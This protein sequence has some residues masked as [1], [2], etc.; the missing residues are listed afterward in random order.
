MSIKFS[1]VAVS[2]GLGAVLA[3]SP[4]WSQ[5]QSAHLTSKSKVQT[6]ASNIKKL[7]YG[8]NVGNSS[9]AHVKYLAH[10]KKGD[11]VGAVNNSNMSGLKHRSMRRAAIRLGTQAGLRWR[12]KHIVKQLK[13][14]ASQLDRR[15]NFGPLLIDGHVVPPVIKRVKNASRKYNRKTMRTVRVAYRIEHRARIVTQPPTWRSFLIQSYSKPKLPA[16]VLLPHSSKGKKI[17]RKAVKAGWKKGVKQANRNFKINLNLLTST[18]TG[19]LTY[20]ELLA[21]NIVSKPI[22]ASTNLAIKSHGRRLN[23]GDRVFR[24]TKNSGFKNHTKWHPIQSHTG[25]SPLKNNQQGYPN[26]K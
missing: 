20:R 14:H 15:Y 9:S 7:S 10:L 18:Y 1:H 2:L 3:S 8:K 17:W 26:G 12:Y 21:K 24:L 11:G 13:Q 25:K 5:S 6:S 4:V 23:V 22:L 19:M 16:N